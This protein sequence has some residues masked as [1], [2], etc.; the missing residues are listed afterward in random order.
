M[1]NNI[2]DIKINFLSSYNGLTIS[3]EVEG[4]FNK[5]YLYEKEDDN[6]QLLMIL[7]DFQVNSPLIQEGKT[8]YVEAYTIVNN[9]LILTGKS[10]DTICKPMIKKD[11]KESYVI[12]VVMPVYNTEKFLPRCIDSILFQTLDNIEIIL[13]DDESID[14]SPKIMNWYQNKYPTRIKTIFQKNEGLS[15]ARNKGIIAATGKYIALVDDD[16]YIHPKMYE[17]LYT[18]IKKNN[19]QV[20][21]AKALIFS[22]DGT[23]SICLNVPN[24]NNL[25]DRN[26]TYEEMLKEKYNHTQDNIYFVAVWNK[27]MDSA[28]VKKHLFP[29]FNHY[30]DTAFTRMIYSYIDKFTFVFNAFYVWDKRRRPVTGTLST[31]N[32]QVTTDQYE[33]HE[34]YVRAHM[35]ALEEGNMEKKD[36]LVFDVL[37][38]MYEYLKKHDSLKKEN[39]LYQ[40][41]KKYIL[42]TLP[43]YQF[44]D[45]KLLK[46]NK[47]ILDFF[48]EMVGDNNDTYV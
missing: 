42:K 8:Y 31:N 37:K 38:E 14:S 23:S 43:N 26:Y 13:V 45:N 46:E 44:N 17:E 11:I 10:S 39:K 34:K 30:E 28:I 20:A 33:F 7:E 1:N 48:T 19:S 16:D 35:Y 25:K 4:I 2:K 36:Y 27:I 21:I 9:D 22:D 12:S 6:Y 18:S 47:I 29:P 3:F 5:Y 15:F 40:I 32:Y 41:V 24:R